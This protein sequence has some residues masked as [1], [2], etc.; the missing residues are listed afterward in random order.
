MNINTGSININ[1]AA[2]LTTIKQNQLLAQ[3]QSAAVPNSPTLNKI[4]VNSSSL[5][6]LPVVPFILKHQSARVPF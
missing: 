4:S 1:M 2:T 6:N 3:T 5:L